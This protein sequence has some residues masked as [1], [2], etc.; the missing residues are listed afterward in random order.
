MAK[1]KGK[2]FV[3]IG[4]GRFGSSVARA[5]Y[6][7]GCDVLAID[8]DAEIVEEI[9]DDVTHAVQAEATDEDALKRLGLRNFDVAVIAIGDDV[10]SSIMAAMLCKEMGIGYVMAKAQNE[11]H[12]KVLLRMGV[13]RVVRPEKDMG[14]RVARSLTSRNIIEMI[15]LSDIFQLVET[16]L[17]ESWA[18]SSL[19]QL[20][21]RVRFGINIVAIRRGTELLVSPHGDEVLQ[22]DDELVVIGTK[23]DVERLERL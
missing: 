17:P 5:L 13:D 12:E 23:Q 3:V 10:Q 18:D 22:S 7:Q 14:I 15:E 1:L 6:A 9:A 4:L 11:L 8:N 21:V 20:N 19:R 16:H 2:Q